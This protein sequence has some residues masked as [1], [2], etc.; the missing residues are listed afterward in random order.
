M[1]LKTK[2]IV[3]GHRT[4]NGFLADHFLWISARQRAFLSDGGVGRLLSEVV[5]NGYYEELYDQAGLMLRL[6]AHN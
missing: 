2:A 1:D 3:C 4:E 6:N 5:I